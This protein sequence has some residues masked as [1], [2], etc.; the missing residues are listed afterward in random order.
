MAEGRR[1]SAS[2]VQ[3]ESSSGLTFALQALLSRHESFVAD[4]QQEHARL[5]A[6]VAQLEAERTSLQTANERV[7]A[8]NRELLSKLETLNDS[9]KAS[10]NTV[11]TLE[12]LLRDTEIEIRR[13][14]A[15]ARRAEEL[16]SRVLDLDREKVELLN[17]INDGESESRS[18]LAR[19][20]ESERKV[21]QLELDVQKI[22]WE[23][24]VERDKHEEIVARLERERVLER[25]LGGAEGRLKGAAALQG[26]ESG[27]GSTVV[28]HFVR[29]ILQDNAN[30]QAGIVELRELLQSSN[31]EVENLR[32]QVMH[33]QPIHGE[34]PEDDLFSK[35]VPLDQELGWNQPAPQQPQRE[36]HV[37]HHYHAKLAKQNK[38]PTAR[39][40]SRRRVLMS[41]GG[42]GSSSP[43]SSTPATP[44]V[45]PYRHPSSP[46][47]PI[48]L[49]QPQPRRNRWSVQSAATMPSTISSLPSSPRSYI[50]D[51]NS[52]I[53]DRLDAGEDSS[54]PTSPESAAGR[55]SPMTLK[56]HTDSF[57][58]VDEENDDQLEPETTDHP[59]LDMASTEPE[60]VSQNPQQELTPK[61]SQIFKSSKPINIITR[62]PDPADD[63]PPILEEEREDEAATPTLPASKDAPEG[64]VPAL[65]KSSPS[66][67]SIL[68]QRPIEPEN[69]TLPITSIEIRPSLHRSPS[70]DSLVSISGMDIH[71]A[72]RPDTASSARLRGSSAY[73]PVTPSAARSISASQPLASVTDVSA[74]ISK[75]SISSDYQGPAGR[76]LQTIAGIP[77]PP[78]QSNSGVTTGLGKFVGLGGW[79]NRKWGVAPTKS[80]SDLR[81]SASSIHSGSASS[82]STGMHRTPPRP[83]QRPSLGVTGA[84]SSSGFGSLSRTPGINQRGSIPGI[85][86]ARADSGGR[87]VRV[88]VDR[89]DEEGL[90][91]GLEG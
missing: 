9:Y 77:V 19:W 64:F 42:F 30:L 89:I 65:A 80:T 36:V 21:R 71:L 14:N 55:T 33:H 34:A 28:S 18:T 48:Q 72:K 2:S 51:Q 50:F 45:R 24:K 27:K 29:D 26:I 7:V 40:P 25:E 43:G 22:E 68:A 88:Q 76:S 58:T 82:T 57:D 32:Q 41:P 37:H 61:P 6:K 69:E 23:A 17:K 13:L 5:E 52:S 73:F 79:V 39:R 15:L 87:D 47:V 83:I 60:P 31:D 66:A 67:D 86:I 35:S 1:S 53:F 84:G 49:N 4:S 90:R 54:R 63:T 81:S 70:Q 62:P 12:G 8:E 3:D 38:T 91:E 74:T 10:D 20:R 59:V 46:I 78:Q 16:D 56:P 85:W 11:K 75:R 44:T